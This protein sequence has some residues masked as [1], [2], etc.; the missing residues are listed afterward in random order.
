MQSCKNYYYLNQTPPTINEDRYYVHPLKFSDESLQFVTPGDYQYNKVKK[1]YIYFKTKDINEILKFGF[2]KPFSRQ[3]LFMYTDMSIY[4]N[5]LGFYYENT[6]LQ[7]IKSS[8]TPDIDLG[9]GILYTYNFGK[10]NVVDIY[11]K[12]DNGVIRFI[13]LNNPN[14]KDIDYKR[15]HLE[16]KMLFFDLN[17]DFWDNSFVDFK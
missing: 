11:K 6:S 2:N 14:E 4:N 5:L 7:E 8:K 17:K 12:Y 15:F 10:F 16:V 3:L 9:N 1:D 13:N